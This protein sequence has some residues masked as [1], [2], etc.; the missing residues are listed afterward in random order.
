MN[1]VMPIQIHNEHQVSQ[2]VNFS[3]EQIDILKN[4]ICKGVS[5]EE[6]QIFIMACNKT[7]L[8]PFMRQIY[9]VKRWDSKQNKNVMT[10]QTGIDG[11]RLIAERT[12][13]YAPDS[14]PT[15]NYDSEGRLTSSTAYI[16]K[17]TKDGTWHTIS[18]SAYMDEYCQKTKDGRPMGMWSNMPRT[19]LSKC[20]EAQAL[21][22]A[23]PAEMSGVYTKEEMQQAED[24]TPKISLEQASELNMILSECSLEYVKWFNSSIIKKYKT[25]NLCDLPADLFDRIKIAAIKNMEETFSK[26]KQE[27]SEEIQLN[28]EV[29]E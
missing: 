3:N 9:A 10:I 22:K 29:M 27:T 26:N 17:Q 28:P 1:K 11:Y 18:A 21:R 25:E 15:Y 5:N 19:M 20:A 14:E 7:Q 8:D 2:H 23:F 12:G 16:K 24:V 4:S 6:F 13:C